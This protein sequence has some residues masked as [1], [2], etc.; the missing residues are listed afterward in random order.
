MI[1]GKSDARLGELFHHVRQAVNILEDIVANPPATA[2]PPS[3]AEQNRPQTATP[4]ALASDK[5]VYSIK[6]VV[7][8]ANVSRT[9]LYKEISEG[10]LRAVKRGKRTLVIAADLRDWIAKWPRSR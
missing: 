2:E 7:K 5:L 9:M 3:R 4:T 1:L 10:R 8:L 6:D